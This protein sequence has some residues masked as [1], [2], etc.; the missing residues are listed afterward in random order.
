MKYLNKTMIFF[1]FMLFGYGVDTLSIAATSTYTVAN[2]TGED[3]GVTLH[4]GRYKRGGWIKSYDTRSFYITKRKEIY[5]VKIRGDKIR[6]EERMKMKGFL[7]MGAHNP[8]PIKLVNRKLFDRTKRIIESSAQKEALLGA[9]KRTI[10]NL[11]SASLTSGSKFS[12]GRYFILALDRGKI[13]AFT[14]K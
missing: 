4:I 2:M 14:H 7:V 11:V 13:T 12:G 5:D 1:L 8:V 3:L 6:S 9:L 10:S